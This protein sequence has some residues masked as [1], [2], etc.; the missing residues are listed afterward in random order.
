ME[1][2]TGKELFEIWA[3]SDSTWSQRVSPAS[4]A[5]IECSNGGAAANVD[6]PAPTWHEQRAS[7]E[8][9]VVIDLPGADSIRLA[10]VLAER[11]YRPVPI[12]NASPGPVG[13]QLNFLPQAANVSLQSI[14][15]LDMSSL[16]R[17]ICIGTEFLQKL[18]FASDAPP[19]FIL[20]ALRLRGTNPIRDDMFDNRWTVF[21]QD[22]PS[23]RFLADK[24]IKQ[25]TLVRAEKGQPLEDLS[26]V[27]LRWQEAGIEIL[28]K[29][30]GDPGAPPGITVS[31]PSRFRAS[32]YRALAIMG[33]RR[34]SVGGFGS[35]IPETSAAG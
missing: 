13:L 7:P 29:A 32:W 6:A 10:L 19:V 28:A 30:S 15:V 21:P 16:V 12:I 34:S 9:A 33:L 4:F 1:K 24:K 22:F 5:Q 17:E 14:V 25:V 18:S 20:D 2:M 27:L 26:H 11:G 3:P 35:F 31:R 23:A 8:S